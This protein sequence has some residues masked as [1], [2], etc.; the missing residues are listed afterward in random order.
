M[1]STPEQPNTN[2]VKFKA[3]KSSE[4]LR[5]FIHPQRF[6]QGFTPW[7]EAVDIVAQ[8]EQ[9]RLVRGLGDPV[10]QL[11][12]ESHG[13]EFSQMP[14]FPR[15][16]DSQMR[17]K[18]ARFLLLI[19]SSVGDIPSVDVFKGKISYRFVQ[20]GL[21]SAGSDHHFESGK[22]GESII[23]GKVYAGVSLSQ[24]MERR[25]QLI[26]QAASQ[27]READGFPATMWDFL[28][29]LQAP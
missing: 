14:F 2:A 20:L 28:D 27:P 10:T 26:A 19:G 4:V 18:L 16:V 8:S 3:W 29:N 9:S 21:I 24:Q 15:Q 17:A 25:R 6:K 7:L 5:A 13:T 1:S 23:M 22:V 12:L 11:V